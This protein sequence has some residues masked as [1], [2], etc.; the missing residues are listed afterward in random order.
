MVEGKQDRQ[1]KDFSPI[2]LRVLWAL[3]YGI[4]AVSFANLGVKICRLLIGYAAELHLAPTR[5]LAHLGLVGV[6]G[7]VSGCL[8]TRLQAFLPCRF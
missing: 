1:T 3:P 6:G 4:S 5:I 8:C 2:S 7:V